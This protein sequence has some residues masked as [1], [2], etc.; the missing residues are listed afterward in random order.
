MIDF[1]EIADASC[2]DSRPEVHM[3]LSAHG[4]AKMHWMQPFWHITISLLCVSSCDPMS[5]FTGFS[6]AKHGLQMVRNSTFYHSYH[7]FT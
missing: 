7:F 6:K 4:R 1:V 5:E 3:P 2:I